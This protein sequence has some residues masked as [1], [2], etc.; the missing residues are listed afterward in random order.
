MEKSDKGAESLEK[1]KEEREEMW[2]EKM[3]MSRIGWLKGI[4]HIYQ[5]VSAWKLAEG[6]RKI[7][8]HLLVV[9]ERR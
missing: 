9:S 8:Q 5:G 6:E 7:K 4:D 1:R 2:I 3:E